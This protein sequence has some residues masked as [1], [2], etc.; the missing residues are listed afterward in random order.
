MSIS[1]GDSP[2]RL[3]VK[4]SRF[5][6]FVAALIYDDGD[7]L[8]TNEWPA[9]I[10]IELRFYATATSTTAAATWAASIT[11]DRAEWDKDKADVAAD[12]LDD[13]NLTAR[14]FYID[15]ATDLLW[16]SGTVKEV[17]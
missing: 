17:T 14:L 3:T 13:A 9:G 1:L 2:D 16:A 5:G 8:T 11:D 10:D 6:D 7:P 4:L 15:G 12:V